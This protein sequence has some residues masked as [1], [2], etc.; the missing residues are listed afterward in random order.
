MNKSEWIKVEYNATG[1]IISELPEEYVF[2]HL[3]IDNDAFQ[4]FTGLVAESRFYTLNQVGR[5]PILSGTK[6][7]Y[8]K[9]VTPDELPESL[10]KN[11]MIFS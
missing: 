1:K 2:L 10:N 8:W 5:T 6:V 3:I 4:F 7:T 9:K 11:S